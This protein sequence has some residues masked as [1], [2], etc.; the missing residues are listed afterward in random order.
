MTTSS[1]FP[2]LT[3]P[4]VTPL[5]V[6]VR[7]VNVGHRVLLAGAQLEGDRARQG[8]GSYVV[9]AGLPSDLPPSHMSFKSEKS[10]QDLTKPHVPVLPLRYEEKKKKNIGARRRVVRLTPNALLAGEHIPVGCSAIQL[11]VRSVAGREAKLDGLRRGNGEQGKKQ[12]QH[13]KD[14]RQK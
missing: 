7:P 9:E 2:Q 8:G 3:A 12:E 4:P 5:A 6:L 11:L 14:L 1:H 13:S 10:Q